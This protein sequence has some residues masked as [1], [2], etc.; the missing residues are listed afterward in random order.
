MKYILFLPLL[1][2]LLF[3]SCRKEDNITTDPNAK[4]TFNTDT[5][6]FDTVFTSIGSATI[7][8]KVYNLNKRNV[9]IERI[10]LA[11]GGSSKFR[12][13]VDGEPVLSTGPAI[14]E[15][16]DSM[17]VFVDVNIDP[18]NSLNPFI[19]KDSLVFLTNGNMQ[20]VKLVAWGQN[21]HFFRSTAIGCDTTWTEGLPIVIYDS[22]LVKA[23]CK[24]TIREGTKI[25]AHNNAGIYVRGV[26]EVRGTLD[27]PVIFQ[28]DRLED[29]YSEVPGQ[30]LG[31]LLLPTGEQHSFEHAEIKNGSIGITAGFNPY[32]DTLFLNAS[33]LSVKNCI[34][35]NMTG[36]GI[37]AVASTVEAENV[38]INN[39]GRN[40]FITN[41]GGNYSFTHCTFA[42][43]NFVFNRREPSVIIATDPDVRGTIV[44][45]R[46]VNCI[47]D[48]SLDD[49]VELV[50]HN[51]ADFD[52]NFDHCLIKT[53]NTGQF[54]GSNLF[55]LDPGFVDAFEYDYHLDT[56][57]PA[58]DAGKDAGIQTDLEG[59][60]RDQQPDI[61]A[62]EFN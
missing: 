57:S 3:L 18:D 41:Y 15:A 46:F 43:Y 11:G 28:G 59:K 24:L 62:Y 19:I 2:S 45:A 29:Y 8:F 52:V 6:L 36:Y 39:C 12:V 49:E 4:L 37:L 54:A 40:A 33:G 60:L 56:A 48:G 27:N 31:I 14:L 10:F 44:E 22:V 30:W 20:D 42:N 55:N 50:D 34:I 23:G 58:I 21:A 17:Y 5:V 38:L 25:Y 16:G 1:F 32:N 26:L 35:Q 7:N 53:L 47:I 51:V 13:N 9:E 61:G